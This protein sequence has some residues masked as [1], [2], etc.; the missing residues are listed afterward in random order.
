AKYFTLND[1][2]Y[3]QVVPKEKKE[4][5]GKKETK[6]AEGSESSGPVVGG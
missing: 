3:E 2:T 1:V 6:K 5:K 4:K